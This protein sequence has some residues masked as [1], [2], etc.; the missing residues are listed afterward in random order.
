MPRFDIFAWIRR[1][2]GMAPITRLPI[3]RRLR[4]FV[5]SLEDRVTPAF[6]VTLV[7]GSIIFSGDDSGNRLT[8]SVAGGGLLQ[9]NLPITGNLVST[10]DLD[11]T[12][13]GEQSALASSLSIT[14]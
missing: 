5:E 9:H 1:I 2:L 8:L 11:S 3:H 14:I 10:T 12:V 4:F 13:P 7:E 6:G